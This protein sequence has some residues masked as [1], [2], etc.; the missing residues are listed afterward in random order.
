[1]TDKM[2]RITASDV[3]RA[4]EKSDFFYHGKAVATKS[5]KKE[6]ANGLRFLSIQGKHF[7][8]KY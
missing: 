3:I 4:L 2:P 5:T 8:R 1:M 7:I 6:L